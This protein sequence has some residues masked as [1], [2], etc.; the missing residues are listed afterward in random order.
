M[1]M[2][3]VIVGSTGGLHARP[4]ALFV[5]AAAAQTTPV[6]IRTAERPAVPAGSMLSVLAL[7]ASFGT[8]VIL[9]ADGQDADSVLET[10]ATLI[11]QNL[12][13]EEP[14]AEAEPEPAAEPVDTEAGAEALR[15]IGV[16][17]GYAAGPAYR[18]VP[19]PE[20][21]EP[22]PVGDVHAEGERALGAL[23]EVA[24]ELSRRAEHATDHVAAEILRAQVAMVDD[25][26]LAEAIAGA[27]RTGADAAHAIDRAF[28]VHRR[29]FH[30]A[31]GYLAERVADLD[32][33]RDRAIAICVGT[34]MPGLPEPGEP[35]VLVARELAPA[36]TAGLDPQQVLGVV[37]ER[38]GP[39]SHSA[40]MARSLGIP[41]VVRCP[42]AMALTDGTAVTVDGTT[43]EVRAG[44][45][46]DTV[47]E[48]RA[49]EQRRRATLASSSGAGR[50]ADG[51]P[52][53]LLANIG[54][55]RDLADP[56][57]P[58][59]EG[60]G[61][62]RTELL[63]LDH[64]DPPS[65]DEQIAA[66]TDVFTQNQGRRTVVRTLDSGADKPLPFLRQEPEP[67]PALGIRGLRLAQRD[68]DV[69]QTQ[70]E[71][72]AAAATATG[73]DVWVMAPMV[74]TPAEAADFVARCRAVG[75]ARAGVMIEIPAAALR[76]AELLAVGDFVSIGTNDLSQYAFAAD[77]E[78]GELAELHDPWQPALLRLVAMC[79][80]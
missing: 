14:S 20:L 58:E 60:V 32:D 36:D 47:G 4:A 25:V 59:V 68:P 29:T 33:L 45:D 57:A 64:S 75:L 3:T 48:T 30:D 38:G 80:T 16:S 8:E 6:T 67:N 70:L 21:P 63:Y 5:A 62:F 39:T 28:A 50:T 53:A 41:A 65:R 35:Y 2:R 61:L 49:R 24:T 46:D 74:A 1:V 34:P 26:A 69:L 51:H 15:G 44:V 12:D 79:G 10:L 56:A 27:V 37:T 7:R 77:R 71:A 66:Y 55:A 23:R 43:G 72:I 18:L 31:G 11:A 13:E 54:S 73:A 17:P 9:E 52:V 22:T 19:P 76:A 42:G 78:C 40:I